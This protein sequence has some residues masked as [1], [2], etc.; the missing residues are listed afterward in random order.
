MLRAFSEALR[1]YQLK[2][3]RGII[4]EFRSQ[5]PQLA[6]AIANMLAELYRDDLALRGRVDRVVERDRDVGA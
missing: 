6:A 3:T 4:I 1:V 5:E 2:D